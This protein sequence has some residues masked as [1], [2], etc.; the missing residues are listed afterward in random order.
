MSTRQR[1]GHPY[2][3]PNLKKR[4]VAI[5]ASLVVGVALMAVKFYTYLLTGSSAILSDALE[6]IINVV[7]SAFAMGSILFSALPP[8]EDHPYGHGKIENFSAGFEG[9]LIILAAIGIF[10]TG[11]AHLIDPHPL[12]NLK[13]GLVLLVGAAMINLALGIALMRTGRKTES[14]ALTADGKH[15]LT[16]VYTS[17]G[18]V[19]GLLLVYLTGWYWLDGTVACLVGLNILFTGAK[20][21]RES[22]A[23]LMDRSDPDLLDEIAALVLAHKKDYWIDIHQLRVLRSGNHVHIDFHMVLPWDFS[24]AKAHAEVKKL[25]NILIDHFKG[26]AS[27]LIHADPCKTPE[28]PIC[29]RPDCDNRT[30]A[31]EKAVPWTRE[32]LIRYGQ[33]QASK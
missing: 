16:D 13:I 1:P 33:K 29:G 21:I 32:M 14:L 28:C 6:S 18:V 27:V 31:H 30:G 4:M 12:P 11:V 15:I 20:L 2:W 23:G 8:D 7:A 5:T 26:R 22:F 24:L 9:A 10:K 25:E 17:G 19:I 3:T